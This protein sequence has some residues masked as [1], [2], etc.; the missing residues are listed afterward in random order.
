M[1]CLR[2]LSVCLAAAV[3][4]SFAVLD[5]PSAQPKVDASYW[6]A[7]LD[8]TWQGMIRRNINPYSAGAGLIHRPKSETPGD[9][10][11]EGVGYGMLVALY[12]NDQASF[13]KMWEKASETMWN[14]EFHDWHMDPS[15]NIPMDG[16][17][18]ATDAE[19]DIALALIFADKL[20][21]A[22]KWT[23]YTSP[24]LNKTYAE[25]AQKLLDKMWDTKQIR[26]EG[27]V[28]PGA[29]WGGYE[30][31]NPGYFSPAWYKVFEKFDKSDANRWKTAV[32]KSYEIISKSPGYSMGMVPDWMTPE[33]GWVGSE[34]LGYNAYFESRAFFKDAIRILWRV[35]IDA[36]WFDE[37][38]A[39]DFLKNALKFINDKG[40]PS[41]AN[42]YQI[43]KAGELLPAEDKWKEFND[44][45]N[46]STWRYRREHSHLTIG[47]W[48]TAAMAVGEAADRIAFSEEMAKF[49]EGGDYFG[50][51]NDTSAA[52]EDTL[53]NEMYFDQFLAWFGTSLMSGAFVNVVDAIDNP[54]TAT[55]GDSSSLTKIPEVPVDSDT[56]VVDTSNHQD[57]GKGN[58]EPGDDKIIAGAALAASSIRFVE[59]DGGVMFSADYPVKWAVYDLTG[60]RVLSASGKNFLWNTRGM[61]GVYVVK[62]LCRGSSF[63]HKVLVR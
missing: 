58:E 57:S 10:V 16:H 23:A 31:V 29:G 63:T 59:M 14:G 3:T 15:G 6:N 45:K 44:S 56:V 33:G 8:S 25:Q 20:V 55:P 13:N 21:S 37:S 52:L 38:R 62:A 53:H 18:A 2:F 22:G 46:E 49:Y 42:F 30:F 32:D 60:H 40:G 5:L 17:G 39:K 12:A 51:A 1:N 11:S 9:A 35:A 28:A 50:L 43:E 54:K 27:I 26:S 61:N 7:A 36:I 41:A 4:S 34:G 48:A 19:E 47:M 24:F